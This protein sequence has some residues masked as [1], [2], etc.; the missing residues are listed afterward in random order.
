LA[1]IISHVVFLQDAGLVQ[2]HREIERGLA[3]ERGQQRGGALLGDDFFQDLDRERLDVGDVGE[4]RIGHD[5]GRVG[6]HEDDLVT[7]LLEGFARL[8]AGIVKFTGLADDNG[9]GADD[10]DGLKV[11][12]FGHARRFR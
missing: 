5:R 3:A 4:L 6:V 1:P 7:L 9:T 2:G 11:S 10:E 12:A 8:G